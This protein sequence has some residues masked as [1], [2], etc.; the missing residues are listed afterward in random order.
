MCLKENDAHAL[1]ILED[2]GAQSGLSPLGGDDNH[3]TP[4]CSSPLQFPLREMV[5]LSRTDSHGPLA[6]LTS[7]RDLICSPV[8]DEEILGPNLPPQLET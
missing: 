3:P 4:S 1:Q 8:G 6:K 2:L 7:Q 5:P